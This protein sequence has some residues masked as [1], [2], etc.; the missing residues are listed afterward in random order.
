MVE[1]TPDKLPKSAFELIGKDWMLLTAGD[2]NKF[3]TMTASWGG[4]GVLWNK[5]VVFAF[6]RPQRFTFEFMKDSEYFSCSFF[7][8]EYRN[9]LAYCGKYS[10]RDVDKAKEC[11]LTPA[12][13]ENAPY[14][15]EADTVIV[16]K[17]L[18][19]QQLNE[20]SVIDESIKANYSGDD[21]HHVF[22]GEIVKV[23]KK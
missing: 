19:V 22:V 21:Y 1:I 8:E 23:L 6:V 3:N 15:E 9:A 10:G 12:F 4:L 18:Y 7:K 20:S 2:E 17:K 14:F 5:N 13:L 11:N 16:C